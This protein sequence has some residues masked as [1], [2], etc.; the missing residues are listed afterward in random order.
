MNGEKVLPRLVKPQSNLNVENRV[1]T[2][3][4]LSFGVILDLTHL[5]TCQSMSYI[6][7][8]DIG[9]DILM[10]TLNKSISGVFIGPKPPQ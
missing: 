6:S 2:N 10:A 9:I 3:L 7:D 8:V 5:V 1:V 4:I